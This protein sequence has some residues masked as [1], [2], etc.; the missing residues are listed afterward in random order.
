LIKLY[1]IF[2]SLHDLLLL[3]LAAKR[4]F[5]RIIL[6]LEVIQNYILFLGRTYA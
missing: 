5:V 3:H 1:L 4:A 6:K 2:T